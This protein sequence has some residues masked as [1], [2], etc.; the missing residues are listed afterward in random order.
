MLTSHLKST[1]ISRSCVAVLSHRMCNDLL[2]MPPILYYLILIFYFIYRQLCASEGRNSYF[3]D[4]KLSVCTVTHFLQ[5]ISTEFPFH[6]M[7][8]TVF[9]LKESNL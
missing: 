9:I 7:F 5:N 2:T 3:M 1:D 8:Q 6:G 4:R